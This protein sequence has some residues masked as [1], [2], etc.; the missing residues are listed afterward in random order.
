MNKW[1]SLTIDQVIGQK[2]LDIFKQYGLTSRVT[3]FYILLDGFVLTN[4]QLLDSYS[5]ENRTGQWMLQTS[6]NDDNFNFIDHRGF[7]GYSSKL[8]RQK[9][10][11]SV[12]LCDDSTY[13]STFYQKSLG[14]IIEVSVCEYPQTVVNEVEEINLEKLYSN[15]KLNKTGKVYIT[16]Y[17]R[18]NIDSNA[19]F[20][21]Y[22]HI[23]YEYN[24][25]KYIRFKT[26]H[27]YCNGKVLSNGRRIYPN[28]VYWIKV[29][30]VK[31][32]VDLRNRVIIPK[33]LL[34]AG[35]QYDNP[36]CDN[37]NQ[38]FID[39]YMNK[40]FLPNLIENRPKQLVKKIS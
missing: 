29:E 28:S 40:Y 12:L 21:S 24:G 23:E 35:I 20:M 34:L 31:F 36:F 37:P 16:D 7:K 6:C 25:C 19:I 38:I 13:Y 11:R 33:D 15:N 22:E 26:L 4:F 3:D 32:I 39:Q 17:P 18:I 30:P 14:K 8:N 27:S 10:P 9:A 5:L 2:Q 1:K